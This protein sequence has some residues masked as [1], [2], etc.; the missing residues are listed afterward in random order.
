IGVVAVAG[1]GDV[2]LGLFAGGLDL[3]F[4]AVAVE[5]GVEEPVEGVAGARL[6][7]LAV[8]VVVTPVAE[9]VGAGVHRRIRVV[10]VDVGGVA[11]LVGVDRAGVV[12]VV[13][14][15]D[16]GIVG[17]ELDGAVAADAERPEEQQG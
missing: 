7:D 17:L 16:V 9:L 1:D 12:G 6:V 8:A 4:V 15:D 11:V 2:A 3:L 13:G 14:V 5:I 10:A